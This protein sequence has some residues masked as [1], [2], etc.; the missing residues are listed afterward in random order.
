[1]AACHP[2]ENCGLGNAASLFFSSLKNLRDDFWAGRLLRRFLLFKQIT[3]RASAAL[4]AAKYARLPG[5]PVFANPPNPLA[6]PGPELIW[7]LFAVP[8]RMPFLGEVRVQDRQVVVGSDFPP[9]AVRT[10][11]AC[12]PFTHGHLPFM[13]FVTN[14]PDNYSASGPDT[15]GG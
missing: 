11:L 13:A 4:G 2:Y 9:Y 1:M 6:A 12:C 7:A 5:V 8:F 15:V 14:P 3:L 10:L